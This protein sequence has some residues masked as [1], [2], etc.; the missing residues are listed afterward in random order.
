MKQIC[1]IILSLTGF[2][3]ALLAQGDEVN[4]DANAERPIEKAYRITEDPRI[5]DTVIPTP[6]FSYPLLALQHDTRIELQRIEA[7]S[8]K[9]VDK[10]P[11]LYHSYLKLGIGTKL[12]PLGEFY[13]N[14]TR[15]RKYTYGLHVK[16]LSSFGNIPGYAPA[17]FDRTRVNLFGDIHERKYSLG[18]DFHYN[19]QGFGYYSIRNE[20]LSRDSIAQRYN[21]AGFSAY[22]SGHAK[23]SGSVNFTSRLTY[24]NFSSMKPLEDSL[25]DW[26][27][28]ENFVGV[29][30]SAWYRMG[31]EIYS[32]DLDIRYNGYKY[33]IADSSLTPLDTGIVLNNTIVSLKPKIS[34]FLQNNRFKADFGVNVTF[35]F[36]YRNK[37]YIYPI[38]EVKYSLFND[39]FIPYVGVRGGLN[40]TTYK[41]LTGMNRFILTNQRMLNEHN[42]LDAYIGIKGT[43]SKRISFDLHASFAS[44]KSKALFITDTTYSM[45]NKFAVIYDTMNIASIEGSI[46]YQL[47]EKLKVDAIGRF[48][49]YSPRNNSYA[50]NLPVVQFIVRANYNLYDKFLVN[51]DMDFEGGRKALVYAP[52]EDVILENGQYVYDLGFI[53]D[54]NLGVE[55]RYNKRISAFLQFN[56]IAGGRYQRWY[57]TPVQSFQ[58][59]GGITARF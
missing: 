58:I 50:W 26:R 33:G 5:I 31:K 2:S 23:D 21:D 40:Q 28:R 27:G 32:A 15:S 25:S 17:R 18:G 14:S 52:G 8:L 42:P 6:Q 19:S 24:N 3:G 29:N 51:L 54:L 35:D 7:A 56:N 53:A 47:R 43:L 20:N 49:S 39:I 38:A 44:Y 48:N 55:Y 36:H 1:L 59:M 45:G 46:S 37:V 9:T 41:S 57:N 13:F 11:Q 10:L 22:Y 12:M 16:H 34:T 4:I 30:T